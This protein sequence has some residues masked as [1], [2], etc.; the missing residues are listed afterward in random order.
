MNFS[1]LTDTKMV[2]LM[3]LDSSSIE[4]LQSCNKENF[5]YI[6]KYNFKIMNNLLE[7]VYGYKIKVYHSDDS[8]IGT[9]SIKKDTHC[10]S[11]L[12]D[13]Y[14]TKNWNKIIYLLENR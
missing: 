12:S 4:S 8:P 2:I 6:K 5:N 9:I 13:V 10:I 1:L 14:I 3:Y 11:L 7:N